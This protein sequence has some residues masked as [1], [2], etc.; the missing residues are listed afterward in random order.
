MRLSDSRIVSA[1]VFSDAA[2][3]T[4]RAL[5]RLENKRERV[6]LRNLPRD[7]DA[8]AVR[9]STSRG[10]VR[11]VESERVT[12]PRDALSDG[13]A[14]QRAVEALEAKSWRLQGEREALGM[15]LSLIDR[16][17]PSAGGDHLPAPA[18][19]RPENFLAGLDALIARRRSALSALRAAELE[20][21]R[22]QEELRETRYRLSAAGNTSGSEE[23]RTMLVI[24]L[25]IEELG[26]AT[27]DVVYEARWATWRPYYHVRLDPKART[28]ECARFADLWQET[29]EDWSE[30]ALKL[31]TA[32]PESGLI[33]PKVSAWTLGSSK[34]YE[35][36]LGL[37]Y[38]QRQ[39]QKKEPPAEKKPEPKSGA[40]YAEVPEGAPEEDDFDG[41]GGAPPPM[42][43]VEYAAMASVPMAPPPPPMARGGGGIGMFTRSRASSMPPQGAAAPGG[44]PMNRAP[45]QYE[46]VSAGPRALRSPP[47]D[48][49]DYEQLERLPAPRDASGGIDHELVV[50]LLATCP[51]G[52]ERRRIGFGSVYYPAR[53]EY[54]L[55]PAAR[56]HAFGRVTVI[57]AE[58]APLISGPASI[59][60]GEI[61]SGETRIQTTPAG[62][63]LV[64]DLG[65]ETAIKSARRTRTTVRTEGILTKEDVHVVEA[66]IEV[67]N[68]LE[69]SVDLEIQDQVPISQDSRI[70]VRLMRT[71]PKDAELD[72]LTGIL[73]FKL[74]L[75]AGARAEVMI[76]YEIEA[77]KDY[78]FQQM[79]RS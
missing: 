12:E 73:T 63:K 74:K 19:L 38:N 66:T 13:T 52:K 23:Q 1:T 14:L 28:I 53:I 71:S 58:P 8:A 79:L 56:N 30:V 10:A 64:L 17:V 31:S 37:L 20:L 9:V 65:A 15:E 34:S 75:A 3:V 57:N 43:S 39:Q 47:S 54:L 46:E 2:R 70:K 7:L 48:H 69:Y 36:K 22:T 78:E 32:E 21:Y 6:A 50:D 67:E 44:P 72:E 33:L 51:S 49:P 76:T 60:V 77:P 29:G 4:R 27:I 5:F 61:F 42:R 62:G 11:A 45:V 16:V 55:R 26:D 25:D 18:P 68:H 35:D 41:V 59:F 24:S 40:A